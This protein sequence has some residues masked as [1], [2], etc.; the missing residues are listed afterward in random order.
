[1]YE[2]F[3]IFMIRLLL[4]ST[5]ATAGPIDWAADEE[6]G[7]PPIAGLHA[8]FGTS[9]SVTP[10]EVPV[11]T[12]NEPAAP[13]VNGNGEH[14]EQPEDDGFTT[15]ARGGRGRGGRGFRG[16]RGGRGG[17]RGAF[18]GGERGRGHFRGGERGGHRGGERGERG[19]RPERGERGE[20]GNGFRG[21][22]GGERGGG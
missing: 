11:A 2:P 20:H 12:Q 14:A 3:T 16:H 6:A 22:R 21:H 4:I 17:E 9:G 10:A 1:M 5:Q 19:E 15:Q 13:V 8:E 7:L 18:R